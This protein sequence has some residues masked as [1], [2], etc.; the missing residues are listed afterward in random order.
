M[1]MRFR[2]AA[3]VIACGVGAATAAMQ[4]GGQTRPAPHAAPALIGERAG[5]GSFDLRELAGQPTVIVFY[6]GA[7][8]PLCMQRLA[9]LHE[10]S[11][12]YERLGARVVAVTGDGADVARNTAREL[13]LDFPIVSVE[14]DVLRAWGLLDDRSTLPA[15]GEFVFAENGTA[16]FAH[17]GGG[18]GYVGDVELIGVVRAHLAERAAER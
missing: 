18:A 4:P 14:H 15:P 16:L 2:A 9:S 5:G 12:V 13:D 10:R 1:R 17:R 7:H 8:C 11:G 3:V 6:R